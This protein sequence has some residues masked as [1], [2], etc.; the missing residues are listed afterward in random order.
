VEE[1][2]VQSKVCLFGSF[3]FDGC[4]TQLGRDQGIRAGIGQRA[5]QGAVHLVTD[6]LV[7]GETVAAADL[8]VVDP[9]DVFQKILF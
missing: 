3:P 5:V 8:E 1:R 6:I 9:T 2:E 7:A 4:I